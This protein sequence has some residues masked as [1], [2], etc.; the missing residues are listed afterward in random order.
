VEE[1]LDGVSEC[2][3]STVTVAMAQVYFGNPKIGTFAVG[4]RY[5]RTGEGKQTVLL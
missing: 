3:E 1:V 2:T 4:S 5:Q